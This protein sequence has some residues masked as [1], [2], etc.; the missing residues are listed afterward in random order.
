MRSKGK[1]GIG[2]P[3]ISLPRDALHKIDIGQSFAEYD[4]VLFKPGVFVRTPALEAALDAN[5][6][7][8]FFVGRRGTGKTAITYYLSSRNKLAVQL[9]PRVFEPMAAY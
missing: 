7:K 5:R 9:Y 4:P 1:A 8:C 2:A 3:Q 6:A